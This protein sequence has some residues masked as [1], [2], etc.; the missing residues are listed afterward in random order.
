MFHS[1]GEGRLSPAD[2]GADYFLISENRLGSPAFEVAGVG[3]LRI[4]TFR[5]EF[6]QKKGRQL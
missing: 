1:S 5:L 2:A 3:E 4:T 6:I